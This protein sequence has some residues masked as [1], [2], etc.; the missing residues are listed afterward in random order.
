MDGQPLS[1]HDQE[2]VDRFA[3]VL[4]ILG[5]RPRGAPADLNESWRY[6]HRWLEWLRE[7]GPDLTVTAATKVVREARELEDD[8]SLEE[9]ADVLIGLVGV[10]SH[11]GWSLEQ[12]ADAVVAKTSI[13]VQRSW[14]QQ[15]DGTW[16]HDPGEV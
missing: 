8:P 16:Q 12:I 4:T 5:T 11:H 13:N 1:P 9:L 6:A 15:D 10:A 2:Q 3:R 7:W 14:V